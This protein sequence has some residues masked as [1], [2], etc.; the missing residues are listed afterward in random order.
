MRVTLSLLI[1]LGLLLVLHFGL[2]NVGRA[3]DDRPNILWLTAEDMSPSLGCYG[4]ADAR[5][6]RIDALARQSVRYASAFATAPVCSPARSCLITGMFATSLGTQRLRSQFPVPQHIRPF[7]ALLRDAGY[8]CT[9]N[10]KTDYNLAREAAFIR[11]AWDDS[12]PRAHWRSRRA[13]QPFFS[14]FNFMTTHQSRASVWSRDQFEREVGALLAPGERQDSTRMTLPPYYPDTQEARLAW[15]RYHD[16]VAVLDKNIGEI[17]DQL[18]ADQLDD[19][20]IVFFFSDHGMG[21]PRGKRCLYDS[22]LRVPLLVRFPGRWS[23]LAP[24]GPGGS[25]DRLV[26]FVDFAPTILSLCR[27]GSPAHFQGGAFLG[28]DNEMPRK[29]VY[30]ARDR[31]DEAMDVSRSVRDERWLYIRNFMSHLSWMQPEAYSDGSTFRQELKRL[32]AAGQLA[33]GPLTYASERRQLEELYDTQSDPHQLHN[34][35]GDPKHRATLT[36]MRAELRRWQLDTRDTGFLT[37]PQAWNRLS[38][39]LTP[40]DIARDPTRYPLERL[41]EVAGAVGRHEAAEDQRQWLRDADDAIRFW[42]A[43][44]L[45]AN[46]QLSEAQRTA[47]QDALRDSSVVVRIE[48]AAAL[49]RHGVVDAGLPVL[50]AALSDPTPEVVLH[51]ARALELLGPAAR[52]AWPKMQEA[53]TAA[54]QREAAGQDIAMFIRFSLESALPKK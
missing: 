52:P 49:A 13:G 12:S 21:M 34:L 54:R 25:T 19:N 24:A 37:E 16:C 35:A 23:H 26:S 48:S 28:A 4:D 43:V 46:P 32:A 33:A 45:H 47:L 18:A 50:A 53:V 7:T 29:F 10:V 31:V 27:V 11:L 30:G 44:G 36:S 6:P 40:W 5:T 8:Y 14:V 3:A 2:T 22:G 17:L 20:T 42:A 39:Q 9:N 51:A 15:A 38:S 41:L 1:V